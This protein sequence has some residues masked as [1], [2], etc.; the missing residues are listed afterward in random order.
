MSKE[1]SALAGWFGGNRLLAPHVGAALA[2]CSWV[3]IVFAGGMAEVPHIAARTLVVNDKHRA[4]IN[5]ARV[6]AD[7]VLR[8]LLTRC[9]QRKAFHPDELA[10][11]QGRCIDRDRQRADG[12]LQPNLEWAAD[13]FVCCWMGRGGKAGLVS[14]FNGRPA[15][16]WRADGGDSNTRYRSAIRMLAAFQRDLR[17]CTFETKD[18]FEFLARCEDRPEHGLYCDPPFPGLGRNYRHNAGRTEQEER[19]WHTRLRDAL[20]QFEHCRIVCRF[21]EH[22]LIRELYP[23]GAWSWQELTGRKQTNDDAPEVLLTRCPANSAGL[24]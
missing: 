1:I 9:L 22:P 13:Y 10:A 12:M 19:T 3:G 17:R 8:P 4:I 14:E 23:P 11:C 21:Y 20:L 6:V 15:I 5:L 16:R 24:F 18:A 7:P 2:G